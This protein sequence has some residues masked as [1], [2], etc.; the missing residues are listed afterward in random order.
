MA[1]LPTIDSNQWYRFYTGSGK[2]SMYGHMYDGKER[3]T[4]PV[5]RQETNTDDEHQ[6]W[7]IFQLNS[8]AW[9]FRFQQGGADSYLGTR[10]KDKVPQMVRGNSCTMIL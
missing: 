1:Q 9:T 4:G 3:E 2:S 7:Q 10:N 6:R 5:S 8:T